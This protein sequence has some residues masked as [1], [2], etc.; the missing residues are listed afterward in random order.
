M[1]KN[2]YEK[3]LARL[4]ECEALFYLKHSVPHY[5]SQEM[6]LLFSCFILKINREMAAGV[7]PR[8]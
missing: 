6:L 5:F 3:S 2:K 8:K 1:L 4:N 7:I